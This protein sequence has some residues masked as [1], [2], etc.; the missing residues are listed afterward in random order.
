MAFPINLQRVIDLLLRSV[1]NQP[2]LTLELFL[3]CCYRVP[4]F[5]LFMLLA[6]ALAL[7]LLCTYCTLST[8][9][10]LAWL[11]RFWGSDGICIAEC[12]VLV[13]LPLQSQNMGVCF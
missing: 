10:L 3:T 6:F 1:L 4:R 5:H 8:V 7:L 11:S 9:S 13:V 2:S 12:V